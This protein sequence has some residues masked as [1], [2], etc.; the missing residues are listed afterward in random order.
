MTGGLGVVDV[1]IIAAAG[2][3]V[4][5]AIA[6]AMLGAGR[7]D[8]LERMAAWARTRGLEYVAPASDQVLATFIGDRDG[9]RMEIQVARVARRFGDDLPTRLTTVTVG[10]G[11]AAS[12]VEPMCTLQ[13]AAWVLDRDGR[14]VGERVPSGDSDFDATWSAR[15][16]D[17][18]AVRRLLSPQLRSRLL[19]ADA[20]GLVVEVA[21]GLVAIPMP[22]VCAD[23]L[24]LDR[25]V[26]VAIAL[27]T[28]LGQ[29]GSRAE[30]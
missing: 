30:G 10:S 16:A 18:D 22:G 28:V 24:E 23:A 21:A 26:A 17:A 11:V 9:Y 13:S 19:D 4:L 25:R 5:F 20:R 3:V 8:P 7:G 14:E 2:A 6:Y 27:A 29:P 12:A 15:G 1:G